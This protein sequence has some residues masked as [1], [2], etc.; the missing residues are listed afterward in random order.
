MRKLTL[1]NVIPMNYTALFRITKKVSQYNV[2]ITN[3]FELFRIEN[4]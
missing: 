4:C 2:I 1:N 3:Y